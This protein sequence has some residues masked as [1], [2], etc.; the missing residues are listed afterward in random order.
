MKKEKAIPSCPAINIGF[1]P[2]YDIGKYADKAPIACIA[3]IIVEPKR[4][5]IGNSPFEDSSMLT[6]SLFV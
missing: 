1:L 6:S 4:G 3:P 2:K 5:E